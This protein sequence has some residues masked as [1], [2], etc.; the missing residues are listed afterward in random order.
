MSSEKFDR[1]L[2]RIVDRSRAYTGDPTAPRRHHLVPR[3]YLDR[4]AVKGVVRRTIVDTGRWR[5]LGLKGV[6]Y[7]DHFYRLEADD[8]DPEVTPPLFGEVLFGE[9]EDIAKP[10]IDTLLSYEPGTVTNHDL[11]AEMS[12]YI[13][14]QH[15]RGRAFR[16]EQLA[17]IDWSAGQ[18]QVALSK[19]LARLI[20]TVRSG[21]IPPEGS[22]VDQA[23]AEMRAKTPISADTTAQAIQLMVQQWM[24]VVPIFASW[25]WAIYRTDAALITSDEPVVLLGAPGTDRGEKPGFA[26][27]SAIV[28]P[29][30]PDRLLVLF[31]PSSDE[32]RY[33]F[34]LSEDETREINAELMA[35]ADSMVFEQPGGVI[36]K[37]NAVPPRGSGQQIFDISG[38]LAQRYRKP[39]RWSGSVK[40]PPSPVSRW[41]E[42]EDWSNPSSGSACRVLNC[43]YGVDIAILLPEVAEYAQKNRFSYFSDP[44]T[45]VCE[46]HHG[47][48]T[49]E[50]GKPSRGYIVDFRWRNPQDNRRDVRIKYPA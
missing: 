37:A 48:L 45:Y 21:G 10:N 20:L 18:D 8:V 25:K 29:L 28:F 27:S 15:V 14:A 9:L 47:L 41:Y 6:A 16:D 49:A 7:E 19:T 12:L 1:M 50:L 3:S 33:P 32:P 42:R 44:Y 5:D 23:A 34:V 2:Q 46:R 17:I 22:T 40:P 30:S 31:P 36:A 35:T 4:W 38:N 39:T 13:A 26:N 24:N 11:I 43:G